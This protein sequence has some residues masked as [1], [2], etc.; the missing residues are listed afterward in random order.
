MSLIFQKRNVAGQWETIPATIRPSVWVG[1]SR[2]VVNYWT[3]RCSMEA[4]VYGDEA[5][6]RVFEIEEDKA[7]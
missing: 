7:A 6:V 5:N 2:Y 4:F 3:S 1:R